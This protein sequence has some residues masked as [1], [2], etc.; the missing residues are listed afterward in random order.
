VEN[1]LSAAISSASG[2]SARMALALFSITMSICSGG[3]MRCDVV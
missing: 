2:S 3:G 1:A